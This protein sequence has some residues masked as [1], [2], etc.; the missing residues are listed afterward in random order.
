MFQRRFGVDIFLERT[1]GGDGSCLTLPDFDPFPSTA[2]SL[3]FALTSNNWEAGVLFCCCSFHR[4]KITITAKL[5][6]L[7]KV[8]T[9]LSG[10]GQNLCCQITALPCGGAE[11][12]G[13]LLNSRDLCDLFSRWIS[14][15]YVEK[16][17]SKASGLWW[18]RG[19]P[20]SPLL[21]S[22]KPLIEWA[23]L[24]FAVRERA[25]LF[26]PPSSPQLFFH[27]SNEICRH[28][29]ETK[30]FIGAGGMCALIVLSL[31]LSV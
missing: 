31:F 13:C 22:T 24:Y 23:D 26:F 1:G 4:Y 3:I 10:V 14:N 20:S 16:S 18:G 21:H 11:E 9:A 30:L 6:R 27:H 29:K 25:F 17:L 8:Y 19:C 7:S 5:G 12:A 2:L 15:P 28:G